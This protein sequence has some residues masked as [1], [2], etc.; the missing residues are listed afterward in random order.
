MDLGK[1]GKPPNVDPGTTSQKRNTSLM[2][3]RQP[4]FGLRAQG[5]TQLE[6]SQLGKKGD[7]DVEKNHPKY[8]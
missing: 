6:L 4:L 7:S 5:V 1:P 8:T 2:S 3:A